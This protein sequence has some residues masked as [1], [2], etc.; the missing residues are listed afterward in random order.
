MTSTT[1]GALVGNG[2]A[3]ALSA[4]PVFRFPEFRTRVIS[5]AAEGGHLKAL[6]GWESGGFRT[7]TAVIGHGATGRIEVFSTP[8]PGEF[9]SITPDCPQAHM[10]ERELVEQFG[11][12]PRG[13][14]WK[15]PVRRPLDYDDFFAVSGEEVHEVAVGPVHAGVI[16]PGH[17][18]FQCH[19][20][21]VLHLE[22]V[23]GYQH[24][25]IEMRL[26][27][28]PHR[29]TIFQMETVAGDTCIGHATAYCRAL[30]ALGRT[31]VPA[32]AHAV[33]AVALELERI[34][35]HVG[36]LGA[37]AGD[38]GFLTAASYCG[39][40][41][42]DA[43]NL[44]TLA[45]GNRIGRG[46]VRPGG[47]AFGVDGAIGTGIVNGLRRLLD[48]LRSG[49]GLLW[50]DSTVLA[51]FEGTGP[52]ARTDAESLGLVGVA[53]RAS[54]VARDVR[55][56]HPYEPYA[57]LAPEIAARETGDVHARAFLRWL[58]VDQSVAY[59]QELIATL[60]AGPLRSGPSPLQPESL[61]VSLVEAWRGEVCHVAITGPDGRLVAYKIVDPSFHN[62]P[63]LAMAMRGQA[64]SDFPLCNKSFNLSYCGHD[65]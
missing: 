54:G 2:E 7:L 22:I 40:I 57:A 26:R 37:L 46:W 16:E 34:A 36:D 59:V 21:Q 25:G 5:D 12:V 38:I 53:A 31:E 29:S 23:L 35:N 48:D 28:G 33:R 9:E 50:R 49:G 30:E 19:G 51:R 18:R 14:P 65:L 39:R 13:H 44:T 1:S 56:E 43:L 24:R 11:V 20:E 3:V 27:G 41:R 4:V 10:F 15:K 8:L 62:W 42:G 64:I 17:F 63:G 58:E 52:V 45:C 60:P 32:A 47:V 61:A 6:F 55:S